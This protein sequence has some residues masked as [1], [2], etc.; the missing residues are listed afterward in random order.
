MK[1]IRSPKQNRKEEGVMAKTLKLSIALAA[2]L[3]ALPASAA[4]LIANGSFELTNTTIGTTNGIRQ[5]LLAPGQWDVYSTMPDWYTTVTTPPGFELQRAPLLT[6]V[7]AQEGS[8][9]IELESHPGSPSASNILQDFTV[10]AGDAG[11]YLLSF[12]YQPRTP[13][14]GDNAVSAFID[15][16]LQVTASGPPPA[17]FSWALFTK[18]VTLG[19]G[20]HTLEFNAFAT[21]FDNTLGGFIDSV[22]LDLIRRD[23]PAVPLPAGLLLLLSGLGGLGFLGRSRAKTA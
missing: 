2:M 17:Q 7:T 19:V 18:S 11:L 22:S 23:A 21:L 6:G 14:L 15:G 12:Y 5:D 9:Y 13:T 4:S 16:V 20:V 10:A 8:R 1:T 3:W